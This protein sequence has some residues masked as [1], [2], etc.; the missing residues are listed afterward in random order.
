MCP[1]AIFVHEI[2]EGADSTLL[3]EYFSTGDTIPPQV[4]KQLA[5][6]HSKL[7]DAV[8]IVGDL[9]YYSS[10]VQS[11]K[12]PK[13]KLY[14]GFVM[15]KN[16]DIVALK[17]TFE[18]L[19]TIIMLDYD[20]LKRD[21]SLLENILKDEFSTIPSDAKKAESP[22]K[23][24]DVIPKIN[25]ERTKKEGLKNKPEIK[26]AE[27]LTPLKRSQELE[28]KI[29]EAAYFFSRK[30]FSYDELCWLYA[31]VQLIIQK[32]N[33]TISKDEIKKKAEEVNAMN[34]SPDELC[35]K[36]AELNILIEKKIFKT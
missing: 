6:K 9:K 5:Q 14:L 25:D 17:S 23:K 13:K 24:R 15:K 30:G 4:L 2:E 1:I 32:G 20:K 35:W 12:L 8:Y 36:T 34:L 26:I 33:S 18:K 28:K 29:Q 21:K 19:E 22:I 27:I 10:V 7:V 3:A 16:E 31:E 11:L